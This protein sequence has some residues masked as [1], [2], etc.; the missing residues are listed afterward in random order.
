[1]THNLMHVVSYFWN[2]F[3][4]PSCHARLYLNTP[5][6][7]K[8]ARLTAWVADMAVLSRWVRLCFQARPMCPGHATKS[9]TSCITPKPARS[10][11]TALA[12][13]AMRCW[14][15]NALRC[16]LP[17]TWHAQTR[18]PSL[19]GPLI[20]RAGWQNTWQSI[21]AT[22]LNNPPNQVRNTS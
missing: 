14:A 15:K 4:E 17:Q 5:S 1:M 18:K 19:A 20:A 7:L 3:D 11:L 13:A 8:N 12:M 16:A 10:G 9:N 22:I 2:V 6:Y 21:C